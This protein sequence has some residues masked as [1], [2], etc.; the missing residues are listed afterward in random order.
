M[1]LENIRYQI[2]FKNM[3]VLREP[4]F[5]RNYNLCILCG[6]CVRACQE[7][8]GEGVLTS[9]PDFHRMHWIGPESLQDSRLQVLRHM[10]GYLPHGSPLRQI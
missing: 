8:R 3:P 2:S 1:G 7:V 10:R 5:D 4:F 6:R 9:N